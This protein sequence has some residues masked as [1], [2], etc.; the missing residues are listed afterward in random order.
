[1]INGMNLLGGDMYSV[2][3]FKSLRDAEEYQSKFKKVYGYRPSV[4]KVK[5]DGKLV[6][7]EVVKPSGLE[8][9]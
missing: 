9:I 2:K 4:F 7:F 3:R 6:G 5:K 1:M 8:K